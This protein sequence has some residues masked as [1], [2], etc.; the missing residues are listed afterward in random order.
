MSCSCDGAESGDDLSAPVG[1]K[2]VGDLPTDVRG[3]DFPVGDVV[4]GRDV[5]VDHDDEELCPPGLDLLVHHVAGRIGT[6]GDDEM[7]EPVVGPGGVGG[8]GGVLQL[9]SSLAHADR[10]CR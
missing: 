2:A 3:A 10:H 1:A 5:A 6:W 9:A 4:G 8:R 7:I